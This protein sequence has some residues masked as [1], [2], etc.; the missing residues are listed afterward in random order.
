MRIFTALG[1]A[2]SLVAALVITRARRQADDEGRPL[3]EVLREMAERLPQD[4]R[5]LPEDAKRA[6]EEGRVAAARRQAEVERDMARAREA[7]GR[8]S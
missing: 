2:A 6:V 7:R 1:A 4:L 8:H 5:T 3:A